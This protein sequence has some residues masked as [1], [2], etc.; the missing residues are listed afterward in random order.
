[1]TRTHG[2]H[3]LAFATVGSS[4]H[5][6]LITAANSVARSPEL[7]RYSG[8]GSIFK[9]AAQ[10]AVF[11]LVG[12]FDTKLEV[13]AAIINTPAFVNAHIDTIISIGN[14]VGQFPCT[15]L[16]AHIGHADHWQAIPVVCSHT[17]ITAQTQQGG[18][19][20]RHQISCKYAVRDNWRALR[21]NTLII[22]AKRTQC[23]WSGRIRYNIDD[24]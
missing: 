10:L 17:A 20:T 11:N 19:I 5:G 14:Q 15:R 21:R 7:R 8:I 9:D 18:S 12:H 23:A 4:P 24:I 13:E 22:P 6:P 16:Q 2:L 1:M 3:R